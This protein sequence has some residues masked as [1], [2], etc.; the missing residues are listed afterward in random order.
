MLAEGDMRN[1]AAEGRAGQQGSPCWQL[2]V[3]ILRVGIQ[4]ALAAGMVALLFGANSDRTPSTAGSGSGGTAGHPTAS[5]G[6]CS[7]GSGGHRTA[8]GG[9]GATGGSAGAGGHGASGGA[10]GDSCSDGEIGYWFPGCGENAPAPA[11]LRGAG[12]QCA[13]L[14][15]GCDGV[16]HF[17]GCASAP[18]PFA[19]WGGGNPGDAC[20]PNA[21]PGGA[22]GHPA[23][24]AGGH[25][26]KGGAGGGCAGVEAYVAPDCGAEAAP[27]CISGNGGA[28]ASPVCGCDGVRRSDGCNYSTHPFAYF[29]NASDFD[30]VCDPNAGPGG[31]G[32]GGAGK[33][34]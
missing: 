27:V 28:C 29:A 10:G 12:G 8:S 19:Y 4:G 20:D 31:A 14:S 5:G 30:G 32:G 25:G 16:V 26:G 15:C 1:R 7:G 22:G 2:P 21:G 17:G 3:R 34:G 9:G 6:C 23:G 18:E 11:C 13:S 33:G 24:G